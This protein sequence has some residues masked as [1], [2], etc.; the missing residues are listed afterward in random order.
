MV[1]RHR[2]MGLRQAGGG[3]EKA[4]G[5]KDGASH[6]GVRQARL[7]EGRGWAHSI[8][9]GNSIT[10]SRLDLIYSMLPPQC[11][12]HGASPAKGTVGLCTA[13]QHHLPKRS[14]LT[15]GPQV[16]TQLQC[17]PATTDTQHRNEDMHDHVHSQRTSTPTRIGDPPSAQTPASVHD[18][19][20]TPSVTHHV[21]T[22]THSSDRT[23]AFAH[24]LAYTQVHTPTLVCKRSYKHSAANAQNQFKCLDTCMLVHLHTQQ[25]KHTRRPLQKNPLTCPH[26]P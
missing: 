2:H 19:L 10:Q 20:N 8:Q 16:H 14:P 7:G 11:S 23:R 15:G 25:S 24:R 21:C 17:A 9:L 3:L 26:P 5:D 22:S 1:N 6:S 12:L 4:L 13:Q 18:S